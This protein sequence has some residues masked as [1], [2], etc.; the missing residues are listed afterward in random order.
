MVTVIRD[1]VEPLSEDVKERLREEDPN[2][3]YNTC[4]GRCLHGC[5]VDALTGA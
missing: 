5:Y 3:A 2:W 1:E 4:C